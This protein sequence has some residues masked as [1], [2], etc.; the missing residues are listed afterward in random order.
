MFP[1]GLDAQFLMLSV[2]AAR[3]RILAFAVQQMPHIVQQRS[4]HQ[5]LVPA[6]ALCEPR[7]LQAV[8]QHRHRLAKVGLASALSQ[9]VKQRIDRIDP[10]HLWLCLRSARLL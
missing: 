10:P 3:C 1:Q 9:Q 5:R 4:R 8:L 2:H 7:G 6:F